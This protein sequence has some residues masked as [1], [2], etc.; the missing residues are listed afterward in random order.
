M[1]ESKARETAAIASALLI[2]QESFPPIERR[3]TAQAGSRKYRYADLADLLAQC[4]PILRANG[5]TTTFPSESANGATRL[6]CRLTHAKSGEALEAWLPLEVPTD[7]KELG[8]K[9]T[10]YRRYLFQ[11]VCG[12]QSED[13]DDGDAASAGAAKRRA[14]GSAKRTSDEPQAG[15][16]AHSSV[17]ERL[18][19]AAIHFRIS[20]FSGN[21]EKVDELFRRR[22]GTEDIDAIVA[23]YP[24]SQIN[25]W[26]DTQAIDEA[27]ALKV[28]LKDKEA[29]DVF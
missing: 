18:Q 22:F 15:A 25:V 3:R 16:S 2:A 28:E 7:P 11:N 5:I 1:A 14:G 12:I 26:L 24:D 6:G 9:I 8:S 27:T 29:S 17:A 19:K 21:Q 23:E 20:T 10:Y 13:D 4:G